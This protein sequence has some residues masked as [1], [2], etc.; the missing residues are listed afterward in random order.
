[1]HLFIIGGDDVVV[2]PKVDDPY[3]HGS[4][5]IPTDTPY[6]FEGNFI[7]AFIQGSISDLQIADARNNVARL[8]LEDGKMETKLQDDLL[9]YFKRCNDFANGLPVGNVVMESH[10]EW[11]PA[12]TTMTEHLPLL[13]STDDPELIKN[14][15]YISPKL[16]TSDDKAMS[17]YKKSLAK[18]DMLMFNLHGADSPDMPSFYSDDEAFSPDELTC[19]HAHVLNTVACFG[20]RYAGGYSRKQSM[21][22]QALYSGDV[23]LY[24]GSLVSVPMYRDSNNENRELARQL[25]LNP[26]TGSEVFMRLYPIYQ[27]N[28]TTAGKALL[29]AKCDYFNLCRHVESD[30]FALSTMLMFCL[31]GNPMLHVKK[32]ERVVDAALANDAVPPAPVKSCGMPVRRA[33]VKTIMAKEQLQK[34]KSIL[35][36]ARGAVDENLRLICNQIADHLYKALGLPQRYLVTVDEIK[37]Q[38]G[39]KTERRYSF[40]YHNPNVSYGADTFVE[41]DESGEPKRVYS[42]K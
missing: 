41:V 1:M 25:L 38:K 11:I 4:G 22:L 29:Q 28:G 14:G 12:S 15:M 7:P 36:Q 3:E 34:P 8:P 20:A 5:S 42:T 37:R 27:F 31:Y 35:D 39:M 26:G 19:S 24:T 9:S 2:I 32:Q 21:L 23:L 10:K 17:V 40:A 33:T 13:Y 30:T 6:C 18:A 16:L